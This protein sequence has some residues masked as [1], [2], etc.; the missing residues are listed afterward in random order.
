MKSPLFAITITAL[1]CATAPA[2][3]Q[4]GGDARYRPQPCSDEHPCATVF[5][6]NGLFG[7]RN[8]AGEVTIPPT[9]PRARMASELFGGLHG[10]I[11]TYNRYN[12]IGLV[13]RDGRELSPPRYT[14]ANRYAGA[15]IFSV[16]GDDHTRC[17]FDLGGRQITPCEFTR[18]VPSSTGFSGDQRG[19]P[20]YFDYAGRRTATPPE[21]LETQ[22]VLAASRARE[23][24]AALRPALVYSRPRALADGRNWDEALRAV[25]HGPAEDQAYVLLAFYRN[26]NVTDTRYGPML[27]VLSANR[28]I[29]ETAMRGATPEQGRQLTAMRTAFNDYEIQRAQGPGPTERSGG[30]IPARTVGECHSNG[31]TVSAMGYCRR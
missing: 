29:F 22:A 24:A 18:L 23:A 11:F 14:N 7:V 26:G 16:D 15:L 25:L 19:T 4:A 6:Q 9:Y 10:L 28:T 21:V 2:I 30:Y 5:E 1:L 27:S 20:V 8:A 13:G 31:G 3:A 17:A 12:R